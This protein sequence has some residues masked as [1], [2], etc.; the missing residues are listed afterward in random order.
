MKKFWKLVDS[1]DRLGSLVIK[2][3][4]QIFAILGKLAKLFLSVIRKIPRKIPP[5]T[6]RAILGLAVIA[7][8][9]LSIIVG[10]RWFWDSG[11]PEIFRDATIAIVAHV[12]AGDPIVIEDIDYSE[13]CPYSNYCTWGQSTNSNYLAN[14]SRLIV[15]YFEWEGLTAQAIYPKVVAWY[16]RPGEDSLRV[17]GWAW[18]PEAQVF[19]NE[20]TITREYVGIP[21]SADA[22]RIVH[23]LTHELVH[24]Q[25]GN[26]FTLPD[27][28]IGGEEW[29]QWIE[30]HTEA[31]TSEIL[32][33]QCYF[34]DPNACRGFWLTIE[35][36]A[37]SSLKM[38]MI[39]KF[40]QK[41]W[42]LYDRWADLFLRDAKEELAAEK[43]TRDWE[44][45]YY[46]LID[47]LSKYG[48]YPWEEYIIPGV[49]YNIP[50]DT[51]ILGY[52]PEVASCGC[53]LAP[54]EVLGLE[55]N[56]TAGLM[57]GLRLLMFLGK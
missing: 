43:G 55:F 29:S 26:F 39:D 42:W 31:A 47:L 11:W 3:V 27:G 37:R 6:A 51:G 4:L 1:L 16:V 15:P 5:E 30:S 19:M 28:R 2:I 33:A 9:V 20:T 22:G 54:V 34:G 35:D 52:C 10:A 24:I 18:P 25:G 44:D 50:L 13:S 12:K 8:I 36:F 53:C 14:Y 38:K 23:T 40:G 32:A 56:D 21:E 17:G 45:R 49:L 46:E 41:G 57:G 48:E 7:G